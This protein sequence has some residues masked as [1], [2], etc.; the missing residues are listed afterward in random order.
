MYG[1]IH[2]H[3]PQGSGKSTFL[4]LLAKHL[5]HP[6]TVVFVPE[7]FTLGE[8]LESYPDAKIFPPGLD[9]WNLILKNAP[10]AV[11]VDGDNTLM[12]K[13]GKQFPS[14]EPIDEDYLPY[15]HDGTLWELTNKH[16]QVLSAGERTVQEMNDHFREYGMGAFEMNYAADVEI[17]KQ[18]KED[19]TP[20]FDLKI[21]DVSELRYR[22]MDGMRAMLQSI[23]KGNLPPA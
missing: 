13:N 2:V 10:D 12:A 19:G 22:K 16:V 15:Q 17:S 3:G 23:S 8:K 21:N 1:N 6:S 9:P 4:R 20:W 5:E 11:I 14:G 7:K 18:D